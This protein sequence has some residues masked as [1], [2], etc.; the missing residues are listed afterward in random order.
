MIPKKC[1]SRHLAQREPLLADSCDYPAAPAL[2]TWWKELL[3][4]RVPIWEVLLHLWPVQLHF[5]GSFL[6]F[7]LL[8]LATLLSGKVIRIPL[9]LKGKPWTCGCRLTLHLL[10]TPICLL[11]SN[12]S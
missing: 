3:I 7:S 6:G 1:L 5:L 10:P 9:W 4:P 2:G 11:H 12:A 8:G